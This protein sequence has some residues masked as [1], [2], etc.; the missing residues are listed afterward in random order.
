[1][2]E[3]IKADSLQTLLRQLALQIDN[4]APPTFMVVVVDEEGF[5]SAHHTGDD[6]LSLLG[7]IE[8]RK[9]VIMEEI[10]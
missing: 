5:L 1:M 6:I 2:V 4:D 3:N 7:A 10:G 8:I 9:K